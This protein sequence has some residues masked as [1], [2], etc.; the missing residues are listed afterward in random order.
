MPKGKGGGIIP[1]V[2]I[3]E[4]HDIVCDKLRDIDDD[5]DCILKQIGERKMSDG[6]DMGILTGM[7][8]QRGIDPNALI[9]MLGNKRDGWGEGGGVWL[10]LFFLFMLGMGGNGWFGRNNNQLDNCGIDKTIFNQ[11]NYEQIQSAINTQ[12]TRQEMAINQLANNL[13]CDA[14][15]IKSALFSISKDVALNNGGIINAIDRCC[16]ENRQAISDCCCKTN[17][18]IERGFCG[19]NSNIQDVRFLISSSQSAQDNLIQ[20]LFSQQNAYLADQFCQIKMRELESKNEALRDK[21]AEL[22]ENANTTRILEAIA[23]K[24]VV[25]GTYNTTGS[26]FTGTIS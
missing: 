16:C 13:N 11:S 12:G 20:S 19:V 25:S 14:D 8:N 18:A 3:Q 4:H 6:F 2:T 7:L 26:T 10:I 23:N 22:R 1:D 24:D 17:L 21:V 5:T 15:S 9:A